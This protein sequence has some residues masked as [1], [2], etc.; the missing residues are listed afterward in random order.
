MNFRTNIIKDGKIMVTGESEENPFEVRRAS[1]VKGDH[2]NGDWPE[3]SIAVD[4]DVYQES[5]EKVLDILPGYVGFY[6]YDEASK[7]C[8]IGFTSIDDMV[9]NKYWILLQ[10]I[11]D[12]F[13]AE[14]KNQFSHIFPEFTQTDDLQWSKRRYDNIYQFVEVREGVDSPIVCAGTIIM[15]LYVDKDGIP[16]EDCQSI[17][18]SYYGNV[19]SFNADY[20]DPT[21]REQVLAEMLFES[22][23]FTE[24]TY[25]ETTEE[26][27][28]EA[29]EKYLYEFE[30]YN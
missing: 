15:D 21:E 22:T 20:T 7:I 26:T 23:S 27:Q 4:E 30:M 8:D 16:D 29:V 12:V 19:E 24:L 28:L 5:L 25:T 10:K 6:G 11:F 17:I 18:K 3:V 9:C 1:N 13:E 14:K 2:I